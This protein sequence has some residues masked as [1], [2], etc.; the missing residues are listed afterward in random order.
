MAIGRPT[1]SQLQNLLVEIKKD[2]A[3][4]TLVTAKQNSFIYLLDSIAKKIDLAEESGR[5]ILTCLALFILESAK[6][7]NSGVAPVMKVGWLGVT[8]DW[9]Y[10]C[11]EAH[12]KLDN[13]LSNAA[14]L[15]YLTNLYSF[16]KSEDFNVCLMSSIWKNKASL[17]QDIKEKIR[18]V[19]ARQPHNI[20]HTLNASPDIQAL[21]E[22]VIQGLDKYKKIVADRWAWTSKKH[23][24]LTEF[25]Y[26]IQET[27]EDF[28]PEATCAT[29]PTIVYTQQEMI[30]NIMLAAA[31]FII[32]EINN[33]H[34][35]YSAK[36]GFFLGSDLHG[37]MYKAINLESY[38][39]LKRD[40]KNDYFRLLTTHITNIKNSPDYYRYITEKWKKRFAQL[41]E[42]QQL[43][44]KDI[45]GVQAKKSTLREYSEWF[46]GLAAQHGIVFT[47]A[48]YVSQQVVMRNTVVTAVSSALATVLPAALVLNPVSSM[49]ATVIFGATGTMILTHVIRTAAYKLVP[50]GIMQANQYVLGLLSQAIGKSAIGT[51]SLCFS[52][53]KEGIKNLIQLYEKVEKDPEVLAR[54]KEWI[55]ALMELPEDIF[56]EDK[57]EVLTHTYDVA[58][59]R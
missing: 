35:Y 42:F 45:V 36:P 29:K 11:V 1:S 19:I 56:S 59:R 43:L 24:A 10:Q 9:L 51:V 28:S 16:I 4:Q 25:M 34:T 26:F 22:N 37:I 2:F 7:D 18:I 14:R 6:A 41:D 17:V 8:G 53:T 49:V 52:S 5:Q 38:S 40:E 30:R 23:I 44:E 13:N 47:A 48:R 33:E 15:I 50:A 31:L 3:K 46:A 20:K 39:K 57:K 32:Q 54:N 55:H 21:K 58:V 12:L 27:C